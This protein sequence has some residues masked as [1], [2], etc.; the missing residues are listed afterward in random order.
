M[1]KRIIVG[2]KR[3]VLNL[4]RVLIIDST[5]WTQSSEVEGGWHGRG[6]TMYSWKPG[7]ETE[8]TAN[9]VPRLG[10][11]AGLAPPDCGLC[12][13]LN[14]ATFIHAEDFGFFHLSDTI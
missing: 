12:L 11:E 3:A 4:R 2:R 10:L 6:I 13:E 1:G 7:A 5:G 9:P 8:A 14:L